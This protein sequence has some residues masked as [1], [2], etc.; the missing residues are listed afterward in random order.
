[1]LPEV[2]IAIAALIGLAAGWLLRGRMAAP[3]AA[4]KAALAERVATVEAMR[5]EALR[6][7]AVFR[8]R[9]EQAEALGARL[10]ASEA[11][12]GTAERDLAALRADAAART[13]GFEA[14]IKALQ[15]AREQL[16]AQ[17][18]ETAGKLLGEAQKA[19]IVRAASC[20][21]DVRNGGKVSSASAATWSSQS[22]SASRAGRAKRLDRPLPG[23]PRPL[24]GDMGVSEHIRNKFASGL[25]GA[26]DRMTELINLAHC[27]LRQTAARKRLCANLRWGKFHLR[28]RRCSWYLPAATMHGGC[29]SR[30]VLESQ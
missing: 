2:L 9:A 12:R 24:I 16:S 23:A 13:E 29:L 14:Q 26:F 11:A 5:N 1:M 17:F 25:G 3:V 21:T 28:P 7:M 6:E 27:F 4:E 8:E 22:P 18:S 10:M 19:M 20:V 15:E 30:I